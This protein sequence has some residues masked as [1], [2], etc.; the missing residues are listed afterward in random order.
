MLK[1]LIREAITGRP[2]VVNAADMQMA[3]V[4][5][6]PT[7]KMVNFLSESGMRIVR[8]G[9]GFHIGTTP[10]FDGPEAA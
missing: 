3:D 1:T 10:V 6:L 5:P 7:H 8:R 9:D 2:I 4:T